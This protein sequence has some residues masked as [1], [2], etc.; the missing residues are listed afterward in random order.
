MNIRDDIE[1]VLRVNGRHAAWPGDFYQDSGRDVAFRAD[2]YQRAN[3]SVSLILRRG[4][5]VLLHVMVDAG[6]GTLNSLLDYQYRSGLNRVDALLLT[7]A[8]FDHIAGLDWLAALCRRNDVPDQ[9]RPLPL[10]C[11]APCYEEAFG[12]RFP[13]LKE[14]YSYRQIV[15]EKMVRIEG[16]EGA[17]LEVTPLAVWHGPTA[18]GAM[19]YSIEAVDRGRVRR[20]VLA[21]DMLCLA[22]G[23][24]DA[25]LREADLLLIDSTSWHPQYA[26][27]DP[28]GRRNHNTFHGSIE[29]WLKLLPVWR[30]KRTYWI[31]YSG[32]S[33]RKRHEN[34]PDAAWQTIVGPLAETDLLAHTHREANR[35]GMEIGVARHGMLV[36]FD[37][38]WP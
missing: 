25:R 1:L 3:T 7:H 32:Y 15:S 38:P 34:C 12:R 17:A 31:H 36:P 26:K 33:D 28:T 10:F 29:E 35:L 16:R 14:L 2:P 23:V 24:S 37:E 22:D 30:P 21:W 9:P 4:R 13:W 19:I 6:H 18:P 20:I 8:H 27:D 5:T 11:S